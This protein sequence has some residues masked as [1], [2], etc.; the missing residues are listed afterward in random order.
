MTEKVFLRFIED[1]LSTLSDFGF[2]REKFGTI[3]D[4]WKVNP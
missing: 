3:M 2:F 4:K 1:H